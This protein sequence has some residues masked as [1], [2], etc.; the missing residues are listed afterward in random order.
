MGFIKETKNIKNP[1]NT[2]YD[3]EACIVI[4]TYN[5]QHFI[6]ECLNSLIFSDYKKWFLIIIDNNSS[7]GTFKKILALNLD[8]K[9]FNLIKN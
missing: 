2:L 6:E 5:S 3:F 9:N 4:V 1:N 7:D 8:K